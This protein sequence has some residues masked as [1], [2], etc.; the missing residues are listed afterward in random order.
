MA[1]HIPPIEAAA[2]ARV[3]LVL[4][5]NDAGKT[6][7]VTGLASALA[8]RGF[9]VGVV[10][11]DLGQSD[12]GPPTTVGLGRVRR[13]IASLQEAEVLGLEF[14]GMTSPAR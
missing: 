6:T 12:V 3:T 4:G 10:D 5:A 1:P 7:L 14:L 13:P 2:A 8:S 11:A 9:V